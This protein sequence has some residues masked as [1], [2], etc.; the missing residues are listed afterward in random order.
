M[1]SCSLTPACCLFTLQV[2]WR[3]K[4]K[5]EKWKW[6]GKSLRTHGLRELMGWVYYVK[7]K[8]HG[9]AKQNKK[10]ICHCQA[11]AQPL[12]GKE[13]SSHIMGFLGRE[14][15]SFLLLLPS[16]PQLLLFSMMPHAMG[17]YLFGQSGSPVLAV[18]LPSFLCTPRAALFNNNIKNISML[19]NLFSSY[20]QNMAPYQ[21]LGKKLTVSQLKL[22]HPFIVVW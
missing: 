5:M 1:S 15:P 19:S 9:E 6:K 4:G 14:M 10:L 12:P 22:G 21:L 8:L 11:V 20:I 17:A 18:S 13:G 16:F 7:Q 2:G 3:R